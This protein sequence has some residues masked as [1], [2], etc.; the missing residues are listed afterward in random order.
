MRVTDLGAAIPLPTP[1]LRL[2]AAIRAE[3]GPAVEFETTH[4]WT[5]SMFPITGGVMRGDGLDGVIVP[6]G[7]DFAQLLADGSYAIEA[8][9]CV[10]FADGTTVMIHN[11]GRMFP[12]DGGGF[13]GR[14]RA[15]IEAPAGPYA[16]LSE[17]VFWGTAMS[18]R[19]DDH[20]VFI[21]L[22]EAVL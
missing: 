15:A 14:T 4:G 17:V 6:G 13:Q 8:K 10:R 1:E 19:G 9:Y 16:W 11:A 18:E 12:Q 5:R 22:W 20:R 21:E 2:R 3:I 7:A